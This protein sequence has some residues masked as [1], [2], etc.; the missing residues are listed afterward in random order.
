MP[1]RS[2]VALIE[3]HGRDAARVA[4]RRA[5][6]AE[7]GGSQ[8]GAYIWRQIEGGDRNIESDR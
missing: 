2:A 5:E 6:N 8:S 1:A 3:Q 7:F 4:T